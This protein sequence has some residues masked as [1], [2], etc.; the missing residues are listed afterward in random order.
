[1]NSGPDRPAAE[2]DAVSSN[3]LPERPNLLADQQL[4]APPQQE[5]SRRAR[6]ALLAASLALFA[7]N[8]FDAT[9]VD[10]IVR[11]AGVAVG[12]FYLHFR[13]KRQV[14][15]VLMD[16]LLQDL[17]AR[18]G[19]LHNSSRLDEQLLMSLRFESPNAGA[20]RAWREAALRDAGIAALD[21]KIESW[22]SA[23]IAAAFRT[24]AL[25]PW[26]RANVDLDSFAWMLSVLWWRLIEDLGLDRA[27]LATTAAALVQSMMREHRE[28]TS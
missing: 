19:A 28:E 9:T 18:L 7:E 11:R 24:V 22:T 23:R 17:D 25:R 4:P 8:G 10:E 16:V 2:R 3:A 13:S 27:A 6:D 15:L 5:R 20:Y 12:G 1:M 21:A 26:A 14:L